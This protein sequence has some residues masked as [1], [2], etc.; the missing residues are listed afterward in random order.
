MNLTTLVLALAVLAAACGD[1]SDSGESLDPTEP[2]T[3]RTTPDAQSPA[4]SGTAERVE[5]AGTNISRHTVPLEDII[6][7]TFDG[8]SVRL[9]EATEAQVIALRDAIA[10]IDN[11][12]YETNPIWLNGTDLVLTMV[13]SGG[14]AWAWPHRILNFHEIVNDNI[15]DIPVLVSYCPLCRSGVIYDRRVSVGGETDTL[16]FG[17]TSAL[18]ENDLVMIDRETNTYWWQ[19]RGQGIVGDLSGSDLTVLPSSTTRWERWHAEHP[20]TLVLTRES[21]GRLYE[22]DPFISY[23]DFID[24]GN[25]PFPVS[26]EATNDDRLPSSTLVIIFTVADETF[27]VSTVGEQRS[28]EIRGVTVAIDGVGG[29]EALL[30]GIPYPSR[31]TFW[32]AAVSAFPDIELVHE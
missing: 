15:D 25:F 26:E 29:A 27:A 16:S 24:T 31:S 7:D 23:S 2:G 12:T 18:Y 32:F 8:G 30:D 10:P 1:A 11:P 9:T 22:S 13:D 21:G 28:I 20:D 3:S 17:N 19:V 5:V 6:F 14:Q 4:E